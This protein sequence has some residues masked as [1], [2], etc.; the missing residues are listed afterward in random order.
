[1]SPEI[2]A[3]QMCLRH[4]LST[5]VARRL[6]PLVGKALAAPDVLRER[7]LVVLDHNLAKIARGEAREDAIWLDLDQEMLTNV[8]RVLHTW[9]PSGQML[10]FGS[11]SGLKRV[12]DDEAA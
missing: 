9:T 8:A 10:D 5:H 2:L 7:I 11:L 6:V 4:G 1:M 12:D 3:S